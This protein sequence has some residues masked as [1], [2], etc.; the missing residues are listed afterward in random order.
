VQPVRR[1][2][3]PLI[4]I[5]LFVSHAASAGPTA[6]PTFT[7]LQRLLKENS[8]PTLAETLS[9]LSDHFPDYLRHHTLAYESRSLH[10]SSYDSPRALV[11]GQTANLIVTFN[12]EPKQ[13]GYGSLEIVSFAPETGYQFRAIVFQKDSVN[14]PQTIDPDE[15][16]W[17]DDHLLIS[18][19]NPRIC[20]A[21]H[22]DSALRPNWQPVVLWPGFYGSD[23][24][25]LYRYLY[26]SNGNRLKD[27]DENGRPRKSAPITS[28]SDP[29]ADGFARYLE[30]KPSH[31]RYKFLPFP[32]GVDS[33]P[34]VTPPETDFFRVRPNTSLTRLFSL[35]I[36]EQLLHDAGQGADGRKHL[37]LLALL[38]C[39]ASGQVKADAAPGL[40]AVQDRADFWKAAYLKDTIMVLNED[41]QHMQE[42][43][44]HSLPPYQP[45]DEAEGHLGDG[46]RSY[47]LGAALEQVGMKAADYAVNRDR[48]LFFDEG[49]MG[50]YSLQPLLMEKLR[51]D[52]G[53]KRD[54]SCKDL[55]K[56]LQ[57]GPLAC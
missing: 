50:F 41:Y 43:F 13:R 52:L 28:G 1:V 14:D 16:E 25:L 7:D 8:P 30:A 2:L 55:L 24:D 26:D 20:T 11:F 53:L 3:F 31:P 5:A 45:G 57:T 21:C 10:E 35:Q 19:P 51:S 56:L 4:A 48:G 32:Q 27:P 46:S 33:F 54:P 39:L 44:G 40:K 15:V 18:K 42:N 49:S 6:D 37:A 23:D 22:G 17:K 47:L 36:S 38:P 12:G 9:L 34:Y 29:E